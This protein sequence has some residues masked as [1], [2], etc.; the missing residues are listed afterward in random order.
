MCS[1]N[2]MGLLTSYCPVF[3]TVFL[4]GEREIGKDWPVGV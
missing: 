2:S 4:T 1:L 3:T